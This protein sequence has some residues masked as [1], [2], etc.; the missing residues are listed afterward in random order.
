MYEIL[1]V[2]FED[3][4]MQD[5]HEESEPVEMQHAQNET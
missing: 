4:G 2:A 5:L 3:N 1:C